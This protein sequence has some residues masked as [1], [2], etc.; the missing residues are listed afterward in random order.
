M[1]VR[2]DDTLERCARERIHVGGRQH[3]IEPFLAHPPDIVAGIRLAVVENPKID[4]RLMQQRGEDLRHL[5]I[6]RI[7]GGI[8]ADEPQHVD[9]LLARILDR[10][11]Q[12]LAPSAALA[13][14]F[15]E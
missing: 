13:L 2:G 5:L 15:A 1:R 9:R 3:F 7:E 6:A 11:G 14:R 4:A 10:E 8:I 12:S